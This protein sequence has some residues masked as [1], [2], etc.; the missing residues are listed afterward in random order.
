MGNWI[1]RWNFN[2]ESYIPG[3]SALISLW[4]ENTDNTYLYVSELGLEFDFGTYNLENIGGM[5]PPRTNKFLGYVNL[6][7]PKNVVGRP[8]FRLKY[9]MNEYIDNNWIDLGLSRTDKQY[10][11]S[12]YPRPLYRVFVYRGLRTEDRVVGDPIAEMIREWGLETVTVGIERQ[13]PEEQVP[14]QVREEIKIANAMVVI[15]TP[16]E[17]DPYKIDELR[18]GLSAIMPGFREWIE[19]KRKQ[20]FFNGLG[21]VVVAGLAV[22]GGIAIINGIIGSLAGTSKK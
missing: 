9:R 1:I 2:K 21:K 12:I 6:L 15:A 17:F 22:V 14:S 16:R 3:E 18:I 5:V 4:L 8:I 7:L 11:I 20:E 19:D 10:F 13:V